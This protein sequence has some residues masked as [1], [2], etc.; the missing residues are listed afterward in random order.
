MIP[1]YGAG[2]HLAPEPVRERRTRSFSPLLAARPAAVGRPV[3]GLE[4]L[5]QQIGLR[6]IA[7][8]DEIARAVGI[9]EHDRAELFPLEEEQL[10]LPEGDAVG[11]R[12]VEP[13][14]G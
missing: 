4:D 7:N 8:Q 2:R 13:L 6:L 12:V 9:V 11:Q 1:E 10:D 14:L 3:S 5:G